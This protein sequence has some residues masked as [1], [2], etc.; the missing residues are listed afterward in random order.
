MAG[1]EHPASP[2]LYLNCPEDSALEKRLHAALAA[3]HLVAL[4]T[5]PPDPAFCT[6]ETRCLVLVGPAGGA[7]WWR[8]VTTAP[9]WLDGRPDPIDRWSGRVLGRLAEQLG[10]AAFFPL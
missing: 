5:A 6:P 8:H 7:H 3:D 4:G 9:E 1:P 2:S 10:G